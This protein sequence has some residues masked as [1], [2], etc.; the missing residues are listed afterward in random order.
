MNSEVKRASL[1]LVALALV[2]AACTGGDG[3]AAGDPT[4]TALGG[5]TSTTVAGE[6]GEPARSYAGTEPAPPF[7]EGLD[8]LN[9]A[10]PI[11]LTDLQGK[12]VLLDFWTY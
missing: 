12:V 8:W 1:S 7:P 3:T 6:S 9:T 2:A 10:D 5:D 11:E 4:T